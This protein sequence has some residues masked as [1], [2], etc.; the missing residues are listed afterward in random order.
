MCSQRPATEGHTGKAI[1]HFAVE[2]TQLAREK[3]N[4]IVF[5]TLATRYKLL[6]RTASEVCSW[7]CAQ[8]IR[9]CHRPKRNR[10]VMDCRV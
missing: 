4:R 9:E 2:T 10:V 6:H 5:C 3:R 8:P 1:N 7:G